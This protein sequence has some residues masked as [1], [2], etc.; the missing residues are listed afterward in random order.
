MGTVASLDIDA[1]KGFT[2][3][4]R[5]NC[6]SRAGMIL[7]LRSTL[8]P[9][10]PACGSAARIRIPPTPPG[11]SAI[12]PAC[13]CRWTC[14]MPTSPGRCTACRVP[15]V[16]NCSTACQ[17]RSIT[18]SSSGR[19]RA[20]SAPLRHLLPRSGRAP[21]HR[22]HRVSARPRRHYR[23]GRRPCHRL[24]RQDQRATAAPRRLPGDRPSRCLSWY[25]PETV[26]SAHTQMIEAGA[27]LAQSLIDVQRLL[28][29]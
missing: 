1:Q 5:T 16:S 2:P 15:A 6:P 8:R 18:T 20:G 29:A 27:E 26:A 13:C 25:R 3:S 10:S 9:P 7:W 24:L 12:P 28:D 23:A 22:T 4:A 21:Q 19:G 11:L 17:P 14:P